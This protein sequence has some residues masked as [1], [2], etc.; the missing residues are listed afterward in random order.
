MAYRT[1]KDLEFLSK[2]SPEDMKP[3]VDVLTKGKYTK[4]YNQNL[5]KRDPNDAAYWTYVA[6]QIQL[7]AGDTF[8]NVFRLGDGIL[9]REALMDVCDRCKVKYDKKK[10]IVADI[11]KK[12]VDK[13]FSDAWEKFNAEQK[14]E[15]LISARIPFN[16]SMIGANG[17]IIL[18][19]LMAAG[20]QFS[21]YLMREF[22][23]GIVV[24][25]IGKTSVTFAISRGIT[26]W[27]G[28]IGLLLSGG[29]ALSGPAYRITIPACLTVAMLRKQAG[30][31]PEELISRK[32]YLERSEEIERSLRAI[33]EEHKK[34]VYMYAYCYN[35]LEQKKMAEMYDD[36]LR[37]QVFGMTSIADNYKNLINELRELETFS[38]LIKKNI[39][40]GNSKEYLKKLLNYWLETIEQMP[41]G[42]LPNGANTGIS[43]QAL[44]DDFNKIIAAF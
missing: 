29:L 44:V 8:V 14:R 27:A 13:I 37:A 11:E 1:D 39:H 43:N 2:V 35:I 5:D 12:L 33:A 17:G 38:S 34:L 3:L 36:I 24:S 15:I 23:Y 16:P 19:S 41:E 21:Y 26:L 18:S 31:T 25:I 4:H 20:S 40:V 10:D 32:K 7:Y 6:E 22:I 28:P 30:L 9:Y 42:F